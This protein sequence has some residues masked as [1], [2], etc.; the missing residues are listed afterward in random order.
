MAQNNT[1]KHNTTQH[2]T[3]NI[4]QHNTIITIQTLHDGMHITP[5]D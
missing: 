5:H 2:I 4:E 3:S 1:V